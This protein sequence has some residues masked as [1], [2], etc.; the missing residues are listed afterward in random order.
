MHAAVA[1]NVKVAFFGTVRPTNCTGGGLTPAIP[2]GQ[3]PNKFTFDA[4]TQN[5]TVDV[6]IPTQL[7]FPDCT[8][9]FS[10]T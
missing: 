10:V 8:T 2:P 1:E 9:V 4:C 3:Y 5:G 6:I 7:P